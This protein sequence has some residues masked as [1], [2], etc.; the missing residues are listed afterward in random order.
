MVLINSLGQEVWSKDKINL[1]ETQI[2]W[3][4]QGTYILKVYNNNFWEEHRV[5]IVN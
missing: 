4:V 5:L 3:A 2:E 1:T